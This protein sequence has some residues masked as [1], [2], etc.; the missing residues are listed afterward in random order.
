MHP[1]NIE[2]GFSDVWLTLLPGLRFGIW[3][4]FEANMYLFLYS[5]LKAVVDAAD[6]TYTLT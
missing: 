3:F 1:W 6:V 5:F 4:Q 2:L